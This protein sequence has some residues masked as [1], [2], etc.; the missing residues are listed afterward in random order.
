MLAPRINA[1]GRMDT[2]KKAIRLMLTEDEEEAQILALELESLNN[3]RKE[4]ESEIF[5]EAVKKIE[6]D[7]LY[8]NNV[9]VIHGYDWHEGVLGIVA[10]KLTEK[11]YKPCVVISVKDGTGKGSARSLEHVDIFE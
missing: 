5:N 11:Y 4:A 10:S 8:K 1:S 6:S 9:I 7:F 2:A 3:A